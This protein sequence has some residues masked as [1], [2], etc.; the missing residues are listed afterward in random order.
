METVRTLILIT[1]VALATLAPGAAV[2]QDAGPAQPSIAGTQ[3]DADDVLLA[4][5]VQPDGSAEWRI[6]YRI[7]LDDENTTEAFDSLQRDVQNSPE[8]YTQTFRERM[9]RTADAAQESTGREM[10]IENVTVSAQREQLPREYGVVTYRFNW[11]GFAAVEDSR[12]RVGDT[13]AGLFLDSATTLLVSW[14][15]GY[16]ADSVD[17]SPDDRNENSVSWSGPREFTAEQPSIVL[18]SQSTSGTPIG[19]LPAAVLIALLIAVVGGAAWYRRGDSVPVAGGQSG[20]ERGTA[21][22]SSNAG[23]DG[24]TESEG[25]AGEATAKAESEATGAAADATDGEEQTVPDELLSN[26]ER[27]LKLLETRGGRMKQQQVVEDLDWTE[28]KTSQVVSNLREDG[29]IETFRIGREN[30]LTLPG[31]DGL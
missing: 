12:L 5:D 9:V 7:R 2:A 24:E 3:V 13:L 18:T 26:E 28:A 10:G 17:P 19:L 25:A 1:L 21:G 6:E 11:T 14:P 20:A 31:E 16:E 22:H 29:E 30:V 4:A 23:S 15:D 8:N 27:V